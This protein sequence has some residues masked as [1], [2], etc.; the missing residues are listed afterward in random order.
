VSVIFALSLALGITAFAQT[1]SEANAATDPVD[2]ATP[3]APEGTPV[4]APPTPQLPFVIATTWHARFEEYGN[5]IFGPQAVIQT[6]P[7][8]VFDQFRNFPHE[9]GQ[10]PE[11]LFDRMGSQYGQF[12]LDQSIQLALWGIHKEDSHY[13]RAGEGNFFK[14]TG[15]AL[16]GTVIVSNTTGGQTLAIGAIAGSYGSWAIATQWWEPK[17]EQS[18]QQILL[19]GSAGLIGKAAGNF[20]HEFWPDTKRKLFPHSKQDAVAAWSTPSK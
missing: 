9:W 17:S 15:H 2:T 6:V 20:F 8:A 16:K 5:K 1:P 13:F 19:W 10:K 3:P 18:A 14:R 12:F 11:A 4:P 7:I